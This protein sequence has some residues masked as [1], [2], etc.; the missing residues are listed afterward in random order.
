MSGRL[1]RLYKGLEKPNT[2]RHSVGCP[3]TSAMLERVA[4]PNIGGRRGGKPR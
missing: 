1:E 4:G 3:R 2:E